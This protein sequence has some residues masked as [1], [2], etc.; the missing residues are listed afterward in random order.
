[1]RPPPPQDRVDF[2]E[3]TPNVS[4]SA[5]LRISTFMVLLLFLD[6]ALLRYTLTRTLRAGMSVHLLFAFEYA[7]QASTISVVALK[8]AL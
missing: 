5:H 7:V 1:M 4:R 8:Y 6:V 3:T 2:V